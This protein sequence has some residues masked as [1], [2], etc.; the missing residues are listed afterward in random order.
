MS[1]LTINL[2]FRCYID[3]VLD[4]DDNAIKTA[5]FGVK[6]LS[7]NWRHLFSSKP[8]LFQ[9]PRQ[10]YSVAVVAFD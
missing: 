9:Q 10:M 5:N 2:I 6:S 1:F 8:K 4:A 3:E 7:D